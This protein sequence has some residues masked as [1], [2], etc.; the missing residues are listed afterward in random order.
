MKLLNKNFIKSTSKS[1]ICHHMLFNKK[2]LIEIFDIVENEHKEVF[3]KVFINMVNEHKNHNVN[4]SES[5]ASEYEMYFNF[6]VKNY[7]NDIIIRNLNW[8]NVSK[9]NWTSNTFNESLDYVS[10]CSY[11]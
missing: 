11:M 8:Q 5:G 9:I 1:G 6:M 7:S 10:I 4:N 2:Y 3:W